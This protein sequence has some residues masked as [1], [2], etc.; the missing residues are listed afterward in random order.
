MLPLPVSKISEKAFRIYTDQGK[1]VIEIERMFRDKDRL[2]M[3]GRLM[4]QFDTT[5]HVKVDDF[6]KMIPMILRPS[7]LTFMILS[8]L[9][10]IRKRLS[11][12][13]NGAKAGKEQKK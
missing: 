7:P 8:P 11:S 10:W 3:E 4:G 12:K 13:R 5:V 2:C 1:S 9:Y 6:F